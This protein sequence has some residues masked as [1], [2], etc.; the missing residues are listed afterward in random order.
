LIIVSTFNSFFSLRLKMMAGEP[1]RVDYERIFLGGKPQLVDQEKHYETS[2]SPFLKREGKLRLAANGIGWKDAK[3]GQM[4]TIA[5]T[6]MKRSQWLRAAKDFELR[7]LLKNGNVHKF[8][9]FP[10]DVRD[11]AT[12]KEVRP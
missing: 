9:G 7:I 11:A 4:V 6:D 12:H 3:S 10:Q 8:D 1:Q 5:A 2:L